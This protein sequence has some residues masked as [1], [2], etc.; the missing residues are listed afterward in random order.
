MLQGCCC[1]QLEC[2]HGSLLGCSAAISRPSAGAVAK[3][4]HLCLPPTLHPNASLSAFSCTGSNSG[5]HAKCSKLRP[6]FS[7]K[8]NMMDFCRE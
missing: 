6:R 3:Q 7:T 8:A 5:Q 2:S 1:K 4:G